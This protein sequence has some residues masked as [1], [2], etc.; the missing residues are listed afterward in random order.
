VIEQ[1]KTVSVVF[2]DLVESTSLAERLDPEV[3]SGILRR[4]FTA[5]STAIEGHGG[6]VEKYIGDAVV[7]VF[8]VPVLHEDDALRAVR[9]GLAIHDA[10]RALNVELESSPSVELC[11][12]VGVNTGEVVVSGDNALGHA[13]S[14]AARLE[15]NAPAG[16]VLIGRETFA[17][18]ANSV[19]AEDVGPIAVKG[20]AQPIAAWRVSS[21][22]DTVPRGSSAGSGYVGRERELQ[23][24]AAAFDSAVTQRT[25]VMLTVVAPPGL[26]KSRLLAEGTGRLGESARVLVG[27][28]LP[29]GESITYAP[30]VEAVA[31]LEQGEGG[32]ALNRALN[33]LPDGEQVLARVRATIAGVAGGSPDETAWAFRRLFDTL[34]AERPLVVVLDD[35]HWADPLLLDLVEYVATFSVG[36]PMVLLCAARPDLFDRRPG[37]SA[38]RP[39]SQQLTLAPLATADTE[40]LLATIDN[41]RLDAETRRKIIETS[42]GV[43][44]F[45]EQMAAFDAEVEGHGLVPAT[46][47]A[48]LAARVDLLTPMERTVLEHAAI[49]GPLFHRD[50]LVELLPA[51]TR[52]SLG[53][54]LMT[55]VRRDFIQPEH[56][57]DGRDTFG[58]NHALI[59]DAVYEAMPHSVR[60]DLHERYAQML[61]S[62]AGAAEVVAHHLEQAYVERSAL[63][64]SRDAVRTLASKAGLALAAAGRSATARRESSR[65]LELLSRADELLRPDPRAHLTV[66]PDLI[67]ALVAAADLDAAETVHAQAVEIART[68][69]DTTNEL[70]AD[71][72]WAVGV[73]RRDRAGWHE[74]LTAIA[75]AAAGHFAT[76]DDHANVARALL[77]RALAKTQTDQPGAIATLKEA[78][79]HAA[80]T[81]D[82]RIQVDVWDDL[83]G[84]MLFGP[85]PYEEVLQFT[86]Q[87]VE[88]ARERGIAFSVADG[89][90]GEAYALAAIGE[91]D[92]ALGVLAELETFFGQL[93][94]S[95][96]QHGE[97]HTLAGRI[98][99]DR[100]NPA[101]AEREYRR[102]MGL[103]DKGG[104]RRWWRNAAPGAAHALLD[105]GRVDEARAVLDEMAARDETPNAPAG[106]F[107]LE[108]EARYRL[109]VGEKSAGIDYARRAVAAVDGTGA[110]LYEGRARETLAE[111]L[112]A[113]G[114][115][116]AAG[117]Q[118]KLARDLYVAKGYLVGV[119]R[120][121]TGV[122][123]QSQQPGR[124]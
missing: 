44:L 18:V 41:D 103:F 52:Q 69:A 26:G 27:R 36:Q 5:L 74:R 83:G 53:S 55:L 4:Y 25:T 37:W 6:T 51:E 120:I 113:G 81:H 108:A 109:A 42:G 1:R 101:A 47:R 67:D 114:D 87:E 35:L 49:E 112:A 57:S 60:A 104:H 92:E 116:D 98:E 8:G 72:A 85:T 102:A 15:Q 45:V 118:L 111:V 12:R 73:A 46:M 115:S 56:G 82:E 23:A 30:L 75:D 68:A 43:P 122:V 71:M 9:A 64:E 28:C 110:L 124:G 78:H 93:P 84:V 119:A 48:L 61:E 66:L 14:M 94:A 76:L 121:D 105:Q 106:A 20:S 2:A 32:D 95:V 63:G 16:T 100:R 123:G 107:R 86:R 21:V 70:R 7:G 62:R 13:I 99:R 24:I 34:A 80:L 3:L 50:T 29:Y 54:V 58:F 59:R 17:L 38:P 33:S 11:A 77:L 97:C 89:R 31:Q 39:N 117:E 19:E 65:A 91:S 90:L 40:R 88:W 79:A 10:I 22:R 96:A